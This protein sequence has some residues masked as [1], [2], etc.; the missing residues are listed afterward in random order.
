LGSLITVEFNAF[1]QQLPKK[2]RE[3]QWRRRIKSHRWPGSDGDPPGNSY[4]KS[5]VLANQITNSIHGLD[6]LAVRA[7]QQAGTTT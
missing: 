2:R 1:A 7:D 6:Y 5:S 3:R 4:M